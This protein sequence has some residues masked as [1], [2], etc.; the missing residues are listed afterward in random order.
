MLLVGGV[1]LYFVLLV[2]PIIAGVGSAKLADGML[3]QRRW[4]TRLAG[5]LLVGSMTSVALLPFSR[6][7]WVA[8]R[9]CPARPP[10]KLPAELL[11]IVTSPCGKPWGSIIKR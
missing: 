11:R 1:A 7:S 6:S 3:H 5:L 2:T 8:A 10:R 4:Y 9:F